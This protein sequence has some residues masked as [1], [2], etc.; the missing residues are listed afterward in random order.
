[1]GE[2][3]YGHPQFDTKRSE[4]GELLYRLKY[5]A[6]LS[7]LN[8]LA[9]NAA[10]FVASWKPGAETVVP[11]PPSRNRPTQPVLLLAEAVAK[12]LGL[13]L[14]SNCVTKIRET[15]ELKDVFDYDERIRLL[16]GAHRVDKTLV[17]NRRVLLFDDLFRSGATM[18]AIAA[19]LYDEGGAADVVALA[20]TRTRSRQ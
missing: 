17:A 9:E 15:P 7:A 18:N 5:N 4:V 14:L 12:R 16:A 8:P 10:A 1:L 6:D 3:E 2:D 20:V 19:A 13:A 11:V